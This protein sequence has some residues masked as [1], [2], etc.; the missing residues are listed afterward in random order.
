MQQFGTFK[1]IEQ[2]N[3]NELKQNIEESLAWL[4]QMYAMY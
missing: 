2:I 3:N 4:L 1:P